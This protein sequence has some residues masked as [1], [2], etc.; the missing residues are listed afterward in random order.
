MVAVVV[1]LESLMLGLWYWGKR[2]REKQDSIQPMRTYSAQVRSVFAMKLIKA[3][4]MVILR[5]NRRK[6]INHCTVKN[7]QKDFKKHQ[8]HH[9]SLSLGSE[10]KFFFSAQ[11]S[12]LSPLLPNG[13]ATIQLPTEQSSLENGPSCVMAAR[14]SATYHQ[15]N[16]TVLETYETSSTFSD[17]KADYRQ[18]ASVDASAAC[19]GWKF[20]VFSMMQKHKS[21]GPR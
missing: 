1:L 14:L 3:K 11:V 6:R 7:K 16:P 9:S 4:F 17:D 18:V 13:L 21:K 2:D 5:E 15:R 10:D 20:S 8:Y 12:V 19:R